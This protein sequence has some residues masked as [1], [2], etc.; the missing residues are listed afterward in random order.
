MKLPFKVDLSDKVA[1]ITGVLGSIWV[2]ALAACGAK[3]ALLGRNQ[4]KLEDKVK[5]VVKNGGNAIYV[6]ADVLDK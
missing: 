5:E 2:D 6:V 3:I 1:V 4:V